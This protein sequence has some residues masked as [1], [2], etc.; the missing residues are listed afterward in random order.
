[1]ET[2]LRRTNQFLGSAR[3]LQYFV[4]VFARAGVKMHLS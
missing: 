4:F 1:M 3:I 2:I